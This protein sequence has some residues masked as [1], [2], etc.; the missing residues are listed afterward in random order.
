MPTLVN[1][2]LLKNPISWII[3]FLMVAV[4][5][6]GAHLITLSINE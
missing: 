3:M 6:I 1:W 2:E 4:A 5:Y